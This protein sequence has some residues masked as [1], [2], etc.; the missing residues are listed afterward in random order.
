MMLSRRLG[1]DDSG[2]MEARAKCIARPAS[3]HG[4]PCAAAGV[5]PAVRPP[6]QLLRG[7]LWCVTHDPLRARLEA[8]QPSPCRCAVLG[9][10]FTASSNLQNS[11]DLLL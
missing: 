1:N 2:C 3:A 6:S 9:E 11:S 10:M 5:K 4:E 8:E 7:V